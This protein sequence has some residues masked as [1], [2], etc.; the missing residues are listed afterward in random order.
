MAELWCIIWNFQS[1]RDFHM[2]EVVIVYDCSAAVE[3]ILKPH[4]W[5]KYIEP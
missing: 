3:A 5:P 1:I 2:T 4:A